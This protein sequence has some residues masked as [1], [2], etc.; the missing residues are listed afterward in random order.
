MT[1]YYYMKE[2]SWNSKRINLRLNEHV[3]DFR[4]NRLHYALTMSTDLT[5]GV[6][7]NIRKFWATV[8]CIIF[9]FCNVVLFLINKKKFGRWGGGG[10]N[11]TLS[12]PVDFISWVSI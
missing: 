1:E 8:W 2:P 3:Q 10:R 7:I 9:N 11:G 12:V 5:R 6:I 4:T